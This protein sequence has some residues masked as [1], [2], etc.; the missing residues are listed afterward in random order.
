MEKRRREDVPVEILYL[1]L[2]FVVIFTLN[3]SRTVLTPSNTRISTSDP[4][5]DVDVY[6]LFC[7]GLL[8]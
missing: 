2:Q 1:P 6:R 8:Q 7:V 4:D 5:W 3:G